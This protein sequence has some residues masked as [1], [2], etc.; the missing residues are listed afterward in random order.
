VAVRLNRIIVIGGGSFQGKSIIALHVASRFGIPII[1]CSDIIRNILCSLNPNVSYYSTSTYLLSQEDLLKQKHAVSSLLIDLIGILNKRGESAIIEGMHFS[2]EF[3]TYVSTEENIIA[4]CINN[5][6][7]L[8]KRILYKSL[9]RKRIEFEDNQTGDVYY[10][11]ITQDN[12]S[13]SK[14]QK[15][16]GRIDSIHRDILGYFTDSEQRII[17]FDDLQYA[18]N[19][20]NEIL[21]RWIESS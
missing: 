6:L 3:L 2:K 15:Y 5:R 13:M 10:G 20:V 17:E 19:N 18:T 16:L 4:L 11:P 7:P 1:I 21:E 12:I 8:E 14:Y 9:T